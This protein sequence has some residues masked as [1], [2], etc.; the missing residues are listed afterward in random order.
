MGIF[1]PSIASLKAPRLANHFTLG[2]DPEFMLG[3]PRGQVRARDVGLTST[4]TAFGCDGSARPVELRAHPSKFAVSVVA[5]LLNTMRFLAASNSQAVACPIWAAGGYAMGDPI[6][7]HIHIGRKGKLTEAEVKTLDIMAFCVLRDICIPGAKERL[8]NYGRLGDFRTQNHGYEWRV[9]PSWLL[10]IGFAHLVLTLAKL[11]VKD[12]STWDVALTEQI[13]SAGIR[14]ETILKA[15]AP[16]DDDA[17]L[18]LAGFKQHF[19]DYA[20][21]EQSF[22]GAWGLVDTQAAT[23]SN[24]PKT[25][26]PDD[27]AL[28]EVSQAIARGTAPSFRVPVVGNSAPRSFARADLQSIGTLPE[29]PMSGTYESWLTMPTGVPKILVRENNDVNFALT[30]P[31]L[32]LLTP[33]ETA[34]VQRLGRPYWLSRDAL[35]IHMHPGIIIRGILPL[36]D[37]RLPVTFTDAAGAAF[38]KHWQP[39]L[40]RFH[41]IKLG[42]SACAE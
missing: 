12:P 41:G 30:T 35:E 42:G 39:R 22:R 28:Y 21:T 34:V 31:W 40:A 32:G 4:E 3:T 19:R 11:A 8:R 1:E 18:A 20:T 2:C 16:I 26:A 14:A 15:F 38:V 23:V 25:I 17:A 33:Q 9:M 10:S 36:R 5:S 27:A 24:L 6:G 37:G 13:G 29:Q 7:G